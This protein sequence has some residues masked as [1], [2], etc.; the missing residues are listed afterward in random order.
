MR[1]TEDFYKVL[2][3]DPSA[4]LEVIKSAYRVLARKYHPDRNA[5][6]D[7]ADRMKRLNRAYAVLSDAA[8]RAAYDR[9]RS[10]RPSA[11]PAYTTRESS[12]DNQA[13]QAAAYTAQPSADF[14]AVFRPRTLRQSRSGKAGFWVGLVA[15]VLAF[16]SLM[17]DAGSQDKGM[18]AEL[19]TNGWVG[20]MTFL[21][22]WGLV[23]SVGDLLAQLYGD[24][25]GR[26]TTGRARARHSRSS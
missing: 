24:K 22:V 10:A 6:S 21:I 16:T 9:T 4:E 18:A 15:G 23:W 2:Q 1:E 14:N 19:L 11:A 7:A 13:D 12:S 26:L 17:A 3:V 25:F 20:V 8:Q 5:S